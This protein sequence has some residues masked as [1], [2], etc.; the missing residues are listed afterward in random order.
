MNTIKKERKEPG[1]V[2]HT[3]SPSTRE[4]EAEEL[5]VSGQPKLHSKIVSQ[6]NKGELGV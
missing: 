1:T 4:A 6:K 2:E 5:R 3:C